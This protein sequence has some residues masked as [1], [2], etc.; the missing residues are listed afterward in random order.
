[1]ST[2][3]PPPKVPVL[4]V[5]TG[6]FGS[7]KLRSAAELDALGKRL[8]AMRDPKRPRLVVCGGTGCRATGCQAVVDAL[9]TELAGRKLES[10]FEL[11]VTGCPGF[12]ERGPLMTVEPQGY[13]YQRVRPEDV[14][15]IM[16]QT[17]MTGQPVES[18]LYQDPASRKK[19]QR[20]S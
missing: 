8:T 4:P 15:K 1:M 17:L 10:K 6:A 11:C 20:S 16:D 13:F 14:P 3:L 9:R 18:L 2:T 19:V 5:P 7:K 12:C